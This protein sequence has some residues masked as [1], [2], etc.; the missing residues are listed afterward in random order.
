MA[1]ALVALAAFA[2]VMLSYGQGLRAQWLH[3][4]FAVGAMPLI[5]A[6]M[7]YFVPV[8]TRG[9]TAETATR[10]IP[11][12][13]LAAGLLVVASFSGA[14]LPVW[15]A[16]IPAMIAAGWLLWWSI[17]RA[18]RALGRP[19]PGLYWYQAALICLL[20]GLAAI[21][22]AAIRPEYWLPLRRLHLH[23]N[24][25]GFIGMTAIGTLQVLLPTA[26]GFADV[27]AAKRLHGGVVFAFIGTLLIASG[28]AIQHWLSWIGMLCWAV[29]LLQWLIGTLRC[30]SA[31]LFSAAGTP[32]T[33]AAIGWIVLLVIGT[34]QSLDLIS[35]DRLLQAFFPL[36]L[37]PLVTG[38]TAYLLPVW[39][40]PTVPAGHAPGR[41][42]LARGAS[43][44]SVMF[45]VSGIL[46]IAGVTW[47]IL[48]AAAGLLI[49]LAQI[50][51][52]LKR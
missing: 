8:L 28:A 7:L 26:A 30:S 17:Q 36:F 10:A 40:A 22:I 29:P 11:L 12:L 45:V 13:G 15:V 46:I 38:A 4:A 16:I 35:A 33:I 32:L 49:Y 14:G 31:N 25:L 18:R 39:R 6:A 24:L 37:L 3:L 27:D 5:F 21:M 41:A 19:H 42:M 20:I 44:R 51:L 50:G 34:A 43:L 9:V 1:L 48:L 2:A 23:L 47:G 52:W